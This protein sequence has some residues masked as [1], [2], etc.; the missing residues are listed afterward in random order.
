MLTRIDMAKNDIGDK[1][2]GFN[3]TFNMSHS[4]FIIAQ[5]F[6]II[7]YGLFISSSVLENPLFIIHFTLLI[8]I[9]RFSIIELIAGFKSPEFAPGTE[10]RASRNKGLSSC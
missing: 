7:Y 8:F 9:R 6:G 1:I 4:T 3:F 5:P 2:R 10:R